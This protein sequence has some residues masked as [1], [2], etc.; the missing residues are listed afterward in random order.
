M[1]KNYFFKFLLLAIPASAF[2]LMSNSGGIA[3]ARTGSPGDSNTSCSACHGGGNFSASLNITT[4]IPGTGYETG[5]E[6][7]ITVTNTS[8]GASGHGF[9][10]TA[11]KTSDNSKVGTFAG[12][13]GSQAVDNNRRVTH[14]GTSQNSWTFKWTAPSSNE[15]DVKFYAAS[16][17]ANGNGGTTGDQVV[18]TS[19]GNIS[20]LGIADAKRL[21]FS[22]FPN[23]AVSNEVTVQLPTGTQ[24]ADV[25]LYDLS[26]RLVSSH[27][28]SSIANKV[29]VQD[30]SAGVYIFKVAAEGKVGAQQFIKR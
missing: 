30:L 18:T 29:N 8:T 5:K 15:G 13:T 16:V 22:M 6:Y 25:R 20:V 11:E 26:G 21:D 23:P 7:N 10:I 2:I 17:A 1:K 19:T 12:G 27:K 14:S 9:Q 24:N 3:V 4:D 28:V